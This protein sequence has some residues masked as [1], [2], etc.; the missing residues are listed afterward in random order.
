MSQAETFE[1]DPVLR[2]KVRVLGSLLGK[3]IAEQ[4]GDTVLEQIEQIRKQA[5]K[6]RLG[7]VKERDKLL[8]LLQNL[9]DDALVPVVRGFNQFLN[10]ANI[11]EQQHGVSWRRLAHRRTVRRGRFSNTARGTT[12]RSAAIPRRRTLPRWIWSTTAS[13]GTRARPSKNS[14]SSTWS[15]RTC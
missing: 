5:K 1:L 15:L 9:S 4:C 12:T 13:S 8:A 14:T 3:T 10:L 2:D 11:A 7:D 6:A